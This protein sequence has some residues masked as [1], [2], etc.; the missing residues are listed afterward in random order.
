MTNIRTAFRA[1]FLA[2][3][4]GK[5]GWTFDDK[6]MA[7]DRE[8]EAWEAWKN[9]APASE[10]KQGHSKLVYDKDKQEIVT[11]RTVKVLVVISHVLYWSRSNDPQQR[12]QHSGG[13][14]TRR[15]Q[16]RAGLLE[17]RHTWDGEYYIKRNLIKTLLH[18]WGRQRIKEFFR[19]KKS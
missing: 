18:P 4:D 19:R 6:N 13:F 5:G 9:K 12:Q 1:G 7:H 3:I 16:I 17:L 8:P 14:M 2:T 11:V 15:E 10:R